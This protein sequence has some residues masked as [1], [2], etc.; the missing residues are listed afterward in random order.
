MTVKLT[1]GGTDLDVEGVDAEFF[2][3]NSDVLSSQ[4]SCVGRR[5]ITVSLDL[6]TTGNTANGFATTDE[7]GQLV[8]GPDFA[9][10]YA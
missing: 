7:H 10:S 4:H 2:T 5:L 8:L 6:H 3:A 9:I 1:T